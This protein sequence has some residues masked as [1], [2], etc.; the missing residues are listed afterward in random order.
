LDALE[1]SLGLSRYV[2]KPDPPAKELGPLDLNATCA[3]PKPGDRAVPYQVALVDEKN[4]AETPIA[5]EGAEAIELYL[6]DGSGPGGRRL[7]HHRYEKDLRDQCDKVPACWDGKNH[8]LFVGA[9]LPS[10]KGDT[11]RFYL[12]VQNADAAAFSPR[13]VE[14]WIRVTPVSGDRPAGPAYTFYDATFYNGEYHPGLYPVPMLCCL[15]PNWPK[16]AK[17]ARLEFACKFE[18]TIPDKVVT[19]GAFRQQPPTLAD[20]PD[21][22]FDVE[23]RRG[24]T[25][26]EPYRVIVTERHA[27][28]GPLDTLRIETAPTPDRIQ[29]RFV[30]DTRTV[31]HT[32]FYPDSAGPKID[33]YRVEIT[34]R[35]RLV[36]G[37]SELPRP[38]AVRLS[39]D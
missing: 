15:A 23:T 1:K 20:L 24:E 31:R 2:V 6:E 25:S 22:T 27:K 37:S 30:P 26:S 39:R 33:E 36:E 13:P 14:T 38:L 16:E 12:S 5:V 7:A 35:K 3:L 18:K 17:D 8:D 19:V 32:F 29:R 28:D 11:A 10:W 34:T 4:P 21:V 9:H